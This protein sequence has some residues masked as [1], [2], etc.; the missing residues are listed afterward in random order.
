MIRTVVLLLCLCAA[1]ALGDLYLHQPRGSN[2]RLNEQS[3]NRDNANRM[4][5]SQ[6]NNRG[7][8][9]KG[10]ALADTA[11]TTYDEQYDFFYYMS[12][13]DYLTT[14]QGASILSIAWAN[15]HACGGNEESDPQKVN[16]NLLLQYMCLPD[17]EY[18]QIYDGTRPDCNN[19]CW[20]ARYPQNP[21]CDPNLQNLYPCYVSP[22]V[23]SEGDC[24][25]ASG[26]WQAALINDAYNCPH[27]CSSDNTQAAQFPDCQ[28]GW[29]SNNGGQKLLRLRDG[30]NT[31]RA[32]YTEPD[33]DAL[34]IEDTF[35]RWQ[36]DFTT[37]AQQQTGLHESWQYYDECYRRDRN[38]GLFTADQN[39]GDNNLG[40][41]SAVF[42]RQNPNNNRQ[43]YECPE[44]REYWPYWHP[45]PW[46][47]IVQMTDR[48]D[49]CPFF[50]NESQN[51]KPKGLC[52]N[53]ADC[54]NCVRYNNY[55]DCITNN[56][57]WAIQGP[58]GVPAPDCI[59]SPWSRDNHLGNGRSGQ[60]NSYNWTL[61]YIPLY[62]SQTP[63]QQRCVL[64]M[65]YN[66]STDDYNPWLVNAS[67]NNN[68]GLGI[69]SPVRQNPNMDI[70]AKTTA[71]RLAVNTAQFGR[72]FQDRT[73]VFRLIPRSP[74]SQTMARPSADVN[75][76][77]G[78]FFG[79][80]TIYNLNVRG[81]RGDIVQ[82]YPSVEYDFAPNA[83][84][85]NED[86]LIHIQWTG[87]NT[88]NNGNPAGDGQAG[89]AGQGREGTDRHNFVELKRY[90]FAESFPATWEENTIFTNMLDALDAFV[91]TPAQQQQGLVF[92]PLSVGIDAGRNWSYV[93]RDWAIRMAS[94][95]YYDSFNTGPYSIATMNAAGNT[96]DDLLNNAPPAYAGAVFRFKQGT[97]NYMCT[98]NHQFTN[99]EQKGTLTVLP[100]ASGNRRK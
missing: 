53:T 2:N 5:D 58:W 96:L 19:E 34:T 100:S 48:L 88:H 39:L 81:K 55:A 87:S 29:E 94:A 10:D 62:N 73:F 41:S 67:F 89:D 68:P 91:P 78:D 47:D 61:P 72:T 12:H 56:G 9:N 52:R 26:T 1:L 59:Q 40:Y 18:V 28:N 50:T 15:Q 4:Y 33:T 90:S 21:N 66:I 49:L 24:V 14:G 38:Q 76:N 17:S 69:I 20:F 75:G 16:C 85:I 84:T 35:Q 71:L 77:N 93:Q 70:G 30:L 54:N 42:T 25:N 43:G 64:R 86:D 27:N 65:R 45:T 46:V 3:A 63:S 6:D 82:V 8:Y 80:R 74:A 44:E 22:D 92:H 98:R 32:D 37:T 95:G 83:L 99:R 57:R 60:F 97:Y 23:V 51:V 31:N 13:P 11:F 36:D 79:T 7:G